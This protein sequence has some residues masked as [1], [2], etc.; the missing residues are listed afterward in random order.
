MIRRP[1]RNLLSEADLARQA[2]ELFVRLPVE[3]VDRGRGTLQVASGRFGRDDGCFP[4]EVESGQ[5]LVL[6]W[7]PDVVLLEVRMEVASGR[8]LLARTL[9]GE[10]PVLPGLSAGAQFAGGIPFRILDA[11]RWLTMAVNQVE[12]WR[13]RQPAKV[14]TGVT[15][16]HL[17]ALAVHRC[18][19]AM[20]DHV[21]VGRVHDPS[22]Q[23]HQRFRALA[24]LH[25]RLADKIETNLVGRTR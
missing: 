15:A 6:E 22:S 1:Q 23:Q 9:E 16:D 14:L 5:V 10:T 7:D 24:V 3:V 17:R 4:N 2:G 25:R 19:E 18:L 12:I 11:G 8:M 20:L 13:D 21:A